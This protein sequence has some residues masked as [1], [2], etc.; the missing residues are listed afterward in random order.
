MMYYWSVG[1]EWGLRA[2]DELV[3]ALPRTYCNDYVYVG[4]SRNVEF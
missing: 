2:F 1:R 3:K 4:V